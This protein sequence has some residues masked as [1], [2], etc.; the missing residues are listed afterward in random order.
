MKVFLPSVPTKSYA[1]LC[2]FR[3]TNQ[4]AL[5]PF[6]LVSVLFARFHF[7]VIRK[8][9]SWLHCQV[10]ARL[11]NSRCFLFQNRFSRREAL[12]APEPHTRERTSV[13]LPL[14]VSSLAPDITFDCSHFLGYAKD[15]DCLGCAFSH[16]LV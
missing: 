16:W 14:S 1:R 15:T 5:F 6:V 3:Q 12:A 2:L 13:T 8:S 4:I 10:V 9:L 11:Q 7:K